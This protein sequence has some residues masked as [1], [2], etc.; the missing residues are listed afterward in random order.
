MRH[1]TRRVRAVTGTIGLLKGFA[2]VVCLKRGEKSVKND[3]F[4][5]FRQKWKIRD[6]AVVFQKIFVKLWLFKQ[7]FY[8]CSL[9]T[10]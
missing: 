5:D 4:K 7:G 3:F 2:E 10:K 1:V 8:D 9:Q 6:G